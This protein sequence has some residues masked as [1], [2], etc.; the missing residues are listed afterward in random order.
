MAWSALVQETDPDII[1]GYNINNFDL[2]Y[3]LDRAS[4]LRLDNFARFARVT[5]SNVRAKKTTFSS[6]AQGTRESKEIS[7]E[8]RVPFDLLQAIQRDY[9]LSS[10]SLNSV[11]AEF[12]GDQKEDVHHAMISVLQEGNEDSRR[13]L[14]V[15]C[16]KDALLPQQLMDKL[17]YMYNYIEMARVTGVPIG[18]LLG[19]GQMIKV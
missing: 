5:N 15:Y 10:Y 8:G 2:P 7:C 11:S 1:T 12:L 17:M 19:R 9:K 18:F 3:V 6:K 13:R 4:T 14:A 16:I